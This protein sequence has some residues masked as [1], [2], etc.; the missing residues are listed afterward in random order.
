MMNGEL[1]EA[2][3]RQINRE[4]YSAYLYLSMSAF[5][6]TK[7][8][9][10][11][12]NWMKVQGE[13]EMTH[14]MKFYRYLLDRGERVQLLDIEAPPFE[15]ASPLAVFEQALAHEKEVTAMIN[16]LAGLSMEHKDYATQ[17]MLQWFVT[18]QIEEEANASEI[19]EKLKLAGE[20]PAG[21]LFLDAELAKRIFVD[22]TQS[23]S[24][25][26]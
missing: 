18:E 25:N 7:N 1:Y 6:E 10:G 12:A 26:N 11:F 2:L 22:A 13:E 5:F 9:K 19:V 20:T 16:R 14:A 21:L 15:W 23:T 17:T 4:I 24:S 3:N 8:L